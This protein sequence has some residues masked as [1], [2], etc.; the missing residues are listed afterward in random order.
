MCEGLR[1]GKAV[2]LLGCISSLGSCASSPRPREPAE[3]KKTTSD[4]VHYDCKVQTELPV[5]S[6]SDST[7]SDVQTRRVWLG[8]GHLPPPTPPQRTVV[9]T[10]Y[11]LVSFYSDSF[12]GRKTANGERYR[13]DAFTAASRWLPFGSYVRIT[14]PDNKRSV[15]VRINDRGPFGSKARVLD[16]SRAAA[17]QLDMIRDGVVY[18]HAE[19]LGGASSAPAPK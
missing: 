3:V 9:Q 5:C 13:S 19:V 2:S 17:R 10:F 15:V 6:D 8:Y 16:L 1:F 7:E 12:I 4:V 11:G 14:R 18:V